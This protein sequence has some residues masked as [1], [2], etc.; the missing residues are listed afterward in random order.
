[1][2]K[3]IGSTFYLDPDILRFESNKYI[4]SPN[5]LDVHESY[6]S[7]CRSAI[8]LCLDTISDNRK[9]ALLP[10]FT[11]ESVLVSFIKRGYQVYP[12]MV[13]KDLLI[14]W[15]FFQ[16]QVDDLKPSV[17]LVHSY[18]GFNSSETLRDHLEELM[19]KGIIMIEDMT[20]SM[21]SSFAPLPTNFHVGS[22]RKWMPIPDGAFTTVP[23]H[24]SEEDKELEFLKMKALTDKGNFILNGEGHKNEIR[25]QFCIAE[26][27]LDSREKPYRM[28]SISKEIFLKT[29]IMEM[30]NI[31]W[32]NYMFLQLSIC[33][34]SLLSSNLDVI[35]KCDNHD[36]CPFHFPVLVKENRK[37][38]QNYLASNDIYATIIWGCPDHFKHLINEDIQYIYD[39]ILCFHIDQR[40]DQDDMSRIIETLKAFYSKH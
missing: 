32:N 1:M 40:Y 34:D 11:C 39:H 31:R 28:S 3:E 38:L 35:F 10:G 27:V 23:Y 22:V 30:K 16:S 7:T 18:F 21:F 24:G 29:D 6:V 25:E 20:Q 13:G 33:H 19:A 26:K 36:I 9:I 12:Y 5:I 8:A 15:D 37:E 4:S 17:I 2:N 14:N